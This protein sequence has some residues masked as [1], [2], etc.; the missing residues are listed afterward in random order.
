MFA[1]AVR[2]PCAIPGRSAERADRVFSQRR[3]GGQR[4]ACDLHRAGAAEAIEGIATRGDDDFT[5]FCGCRC[6]THFRIRGRLA[7]R[8]AGNLDRLIAVRFDPKLVAAFGN[9][10]NRESSLPVGP[11]NGLDWQ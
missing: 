2:P 8:D 6:K 4:V 10:A 3:L 7:S 11:V 1:C 9:R 5:E